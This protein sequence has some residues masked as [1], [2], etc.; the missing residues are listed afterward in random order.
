MH[1]KEQKR[2]LRERIWKLM[3]EENIAT[4]PF[5][6]ENRIPNFEGSEEAARLAT[7]LEEWKKA[8]VIFSNPDSAQK[9]LRELV[10]KEGKIL[11]MA[12]PKLKEGY[13]MIEP[14]EVKGKEKE[15]SSIAGAF[16]FG[17]K[18]ERLLK[19]DLIITGCVAVDKR[20]FRLGKGG[21]YGDREISTFL[22]EF[23]EIKVITTVHD[24][25]IVEEVPLEEFDTCVDYIVTPTKIIKL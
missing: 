2:T 15:A 22:K 12:T 4:P 5:P 10:L 6:L 17:K 8:R 7:T 3:K 23:G 11:I 21:G 13:L 1:V 25:Q 14:E 16:E 24:L 19:P 18:L 20:G 9:K